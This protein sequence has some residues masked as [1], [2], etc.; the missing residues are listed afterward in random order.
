[1]PFRRASINHVT[2]PRYC[3]KSRHS[4]ERR[5]LIAVRMSRIYRDRATQL[6]Y[7]SNNAIRRAAQSICH[8]T[9]RVLAGELRRASRNT[10]WPTWNL[11]IPTGPEFAPSGKSRTGR[12]F[13]C[14]AS[15]HLPAKT[16]PFCFQAS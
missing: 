2:K 15:D 3:S 8:P 16:P 13:C 6:C 1:M 12:T 5:S 7:C 11:M 10:R 14:E 4:A 9:W